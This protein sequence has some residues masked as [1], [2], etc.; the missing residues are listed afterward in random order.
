MLPSLSIGEKSH[1][2]MVQDENLYYYYEDWTSNGAT[3]IHKAACSRCNYGL[4]FSEEHQ[5]GKVPFGLDHSQQWIMQFSMLIKEAYH[6][7]LANF[8]L[9][10]VTYF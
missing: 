5:R 8:V 2:I 9:I 1:T 7:L 3:H 6:Q 10:K 4:G